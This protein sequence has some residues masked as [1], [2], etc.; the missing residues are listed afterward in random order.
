MWTS[1]SYGIV[2]SV[3]FVKPVYSVIGLTPFSNLRI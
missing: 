1:D 2:G 3:R